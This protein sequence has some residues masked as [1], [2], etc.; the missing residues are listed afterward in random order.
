MVSFLSKQNTALLQ[1][2][3]QEESI[4]LGMESF[5]QMASDFAH[6][7]GQ[8]RLPLMEMN[9]QFLL[10]IRLAYQQ[11]QQMQS[12]PPL[13]STTAATMPSRPQGVRSKNVSFDQELELH[14]KHFQQF[15]APPPPTPPV[16][17]DPEPSSNSSA[18]SME[19]DL[20]TLM[21]KTINE[22]KYDSAL[23]SQFTGRKL[24]IGSMIEQTS[25]TEDVIDIE[26]ISGGGGGPT[27]PA[28]SAFSSSVEVAF[29]GENKMTDF[30][31]KLKTTNSSPSSSSLSPIV[32]ISRNLPATTT[33]TITPT[34]EDLQQMVA[35][36]QSELEDTKQIVSHL[37]EEFAAFKIYI[38]NIG[39][40]ET[41]LSLS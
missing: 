18:S 23:P 28:M 33:T 3:L 15:A 20:Q 5:H 34:N 30:F 17:Q 6:K 26:G 41:P 13:P 36:L 24:Q 37:S 8:T 11:L 4:F 40:K 16:F 14:R 9:K 7:K 39:L 21:T 29:N 10:M 38:Y 32:D 22:R 27:Q 35:K 12:Q 25:H 31:S 2:I 1:E 19:A